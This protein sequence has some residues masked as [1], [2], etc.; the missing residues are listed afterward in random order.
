MDKGPSTWIMEIPSSSKDKPKGV[1]VEGSKVRMMVR[2]LFKTSPR[3]AEKPSSKSI[4]NTQKGE[5]DGKLTGAAVLSFNKRPTKNLK[6]SAPIPRKPTSQP[7]KP[8]IESQPM[9]GPVTIPPPTS[10]LPTYTQKDILYKGKGKPLASSRDSKFSSISSLPS[11]FSVN[12]PSPTLSS[13]TTTSTSPATAYTTLNPHEFAHLNSLVRRCARRL[14][15]QDLLASNL[16][17]NLLHIFT[18]KE[19]QLHAQKHLRR[20]EQQHMLQTLFRVREHCGRLFLRKAAF[21]QHAFSV[22]ERLKKVSTESERDAKARIP[23]ACTSWQ[24]SE[25]LRFVVCREAVGDF[26]K[27]M[28][29]DRQFQTGLDG[30]IQNSILECARE[31]RWVAGGGVGEKVMMGRFVGFVEAR[32]RKLEEYYDILEVLV[33]QVEEAVMREKK[34][35]LMWVEACPSWVR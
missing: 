15:Q 23:E 26:V 5:K 34:G 3:P 18:S 6:P 1:D 30:D 27:E 17:N 35:D 8:S 33:K 24:A 11:G 2:R 22:L 13:V 31:G 4:P 14:H 10:D 16:A 20:S 32:G 25:G 9:A 19:A 29:R 28:A 12:P 21:S 7:P